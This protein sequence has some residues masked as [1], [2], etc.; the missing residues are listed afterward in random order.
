LTV[1][2]WCS[3]VSSIPER[4]H[5][6]VLL[7]GG[8]PLELPGFSRLVEKLRA[9]NWGVSIDS[10]GVG[11]ERLAEELAAIGGFHVTVSLD[12][13]SEIHDR[14]RGVLGTYERARRGVDAL[15]AAC[16]RAGT[17]VTLSLN[18]TLGQE[19]LE[20]LSQF[21]D[22]ARQWGIPVVCVVPRY[23]VEPTAGREQERALAKF[24]VVAWAWRGFPSEAVR[25]DSERLR[26]ALEAF[27]ARL[28]AIEAYPF[29]PLSD[30]EYED[31]LCRWE[32]PVGL[33]QCANAWT[34]L[35][36][37]PNGDANFCVDFPDWAIGN[38]REQNLEQ[39]WLG[40]RANAFRQRIATGLLPVC[41]RCGA[42]YMSRQCDG[43]L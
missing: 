39:L 43:E 12:G 27:R 7:R 41:R 16:E 23:W 10:N 8:E 19:N 35:D 3:L 26:G 31:W 37:Q 30:A 6:Q 11:L 33:Q 1:D 25:C 2:E 15:R 42:K 40:A 18:W 20:H 38:V 5:P 32:V 14:I 13:P 24:G 17:K 28:G 9:R 29:L 4:L 22:L 36:V 21:P 34:L